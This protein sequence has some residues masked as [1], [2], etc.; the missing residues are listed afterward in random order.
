MLM[1]RAGGTGCTQRETSG[2]KRT[3]IHVALS[4]VEL[5]PVVYQC[6]IDRQSGVPIITGR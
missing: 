1:L 4:A 2:N 6:G 5:S 3:A